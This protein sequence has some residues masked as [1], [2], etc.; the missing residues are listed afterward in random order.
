MAKIKKKIKKEKSIQLNYF[1]LKYFK[2]N[3]LWLTVPLY[4]KKVHSELSWKILI[5]IIEKKT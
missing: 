5:N 1:L 4:R 3:I 2:M